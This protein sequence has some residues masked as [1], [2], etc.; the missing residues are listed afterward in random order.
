MVEPGLLAWDS[1]D[2]LYLLDDG[3]G[4][5][6]MDIGGVVQ[7]FVLVLYLLITNV[8]GVNLHCKD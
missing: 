7:V 3:D 8:H 4:I 2:N 6:T 5:D 1:L